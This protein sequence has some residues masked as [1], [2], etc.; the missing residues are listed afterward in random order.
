MAQKRNR[1]VAVVQCLGGCHAEAVIPRGD[2]AGDCS[3]VLADHPDGILKCKW[4]CLGMGSCVA[5]CKSDAIHINSFGVAEV[6]RGK[7]VGCGLCVKA[8]P[9]G[10]FEPG[11][12]SPDKEGLLSGL[13]CLRY[14][15]KEL[16]GGCRQD[17]E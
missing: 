1:K 13:Y 12:G 14:L 6:D 8:C 15:C 7:C 11:R 5:A 4:G 10:L 9:L 16:S 2:L 17:R 3:Q